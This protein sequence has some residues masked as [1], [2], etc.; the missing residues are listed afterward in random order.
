MKASEGRIGRVF[1]IRLEDG[2]MLPDCI[3]QFAA[4]QKIAIAQA[5][6]LGGIGGGQ[7]VVGPRDSDSR[8]PEPMLLPID[9]AHEVV[10]LGVVAPDVE[11]RPILHMH[12]AMGRSGATLTG[13]VRPGVRTWLVG[14]VVLQEI[15]GAEARRI[16][17]PQSGFALLQPGE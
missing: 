11:G 12:A 15:V 6:L 8:P 4:E 14:E 10:G 13:C 9:G 7:A 3:E 5:T 17:D 1:V 16:L 2:D